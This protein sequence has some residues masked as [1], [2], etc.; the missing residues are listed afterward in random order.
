MHKTLKKF[1]YPSTLIKKYKHWNLLLN[2][3]QFTLGSVVLVNIES[4]TEFSKL[5]TESL[6][7][8]AKIV[9]EIEFKLKLL[10]N[11]DKINH[12]MLMMVD[13]HVHFH[14]IPRY[15]EQRKF[16]RHMF[17]DLG[18]PVQPNL[19]FTN[20]IK[21]TTFK[22]LKEEMI[23]A[24]KPKSDNN[25][26]KMYERVYTTGVF[27]LFHIGHLNILKQSK[28]IA[29]SLIVGVSTDDL[30]QRAKNKTPVIPYEDRVKLVESIRYVDKVVPQ[31]NKNKQE[32][33]EKY[34]IDA[35]TVG[36]DWKGRYPPVTCDLVYFPYT[37][38]TNST[39]MRQ[40]IADGEIIDLP[41]Q[42]K[43][44]AKK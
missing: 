11:Y 5:S 34:K 17:I 36:D 24:F 42:M 10:F 43:N 32:A 31:I 41:L 6:F 37:P 40:D 15:S 26:K 14:I 39:K 30:V 29:E 27:D 33:V 18:W 12:I 13:P 1:Q 28:E 25:V 19:D 2:P 38:I 44:P 3:I 8:Y 22:N 21:P 35:I 7:E 4:A 23:Q 16:E 20:D 9:P